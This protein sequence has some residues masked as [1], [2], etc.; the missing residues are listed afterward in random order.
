GGAAS[1]ALQPR[2]RPLGA[3]LGRRPALVT[4]FSQVSCAGAAA[5]LS[6]R[7]PP[8]LRG[9]GAPLSSGFTRCSRPSTGAK[10]L[11]EGFKENAPSPQFRRSALGLLR[12]S[13][14]QQPKGPLP[15]PGRHSTD[16]KAAGAF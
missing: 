8:S 6:T 5:P 10:M 4:N 13:P 7:S 3:P 9:A 14:L 12:L 11:K 1:S 2:P 15:G 16:P